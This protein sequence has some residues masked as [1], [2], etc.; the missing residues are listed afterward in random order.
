MGARSKKVLELVSGW[1]AVELVLKCFVFGIWQLMQIAVKRLWKGHRRKSP[2]NC[3][4]VEL[5]VVSS[6]GTHCYI[7]VMVSYKQ[8]IG[9][10]VLIQ[11][12]LVNLSPE[13]Y[14]NDL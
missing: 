11:I 4:P 14:K 13:F 8:N 6:I 12:L 2:K 10:F 9:I 3:P 1:E 7:K 5:T